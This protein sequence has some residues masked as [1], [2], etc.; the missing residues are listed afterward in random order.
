[1]LPPGMSEAVAFSPAGDLIAFGD[2]LGTITLLTWPGQVETSEIRAHEGKGGVLSLAFHP[3]GKELASG[4]DDSTVVIWDLSDGGSLLRD[5]VHS[6]EV[7]GLAF[8]PDGSALVS[9]DQKGGVRVL[10]APKPQ[11]SRTDPLT[12]NEIHEKR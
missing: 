11:F 7:R 3:N 10:E 8:A 12:K 6:G 5:R 1:V 9:V 2:G 4:G